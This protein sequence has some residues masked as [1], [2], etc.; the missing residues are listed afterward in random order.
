MRI[1]VK[2]GCSIMLGVWL[3]LDGV[4]IGAVQA[5]SE[6]WREF[7]ALDNG[8]GRG[9][10]APSQQAATLRKL[11]YDGISYNYTTPADLDVWLKEVQ[12]HGL[13]LHGLYFPVRIDEPEPYPAG[14][15]EAVAKLKGRETVLWM[16]LPMPPGQGNHETKAI[17]RVQDLADLAKTAGLRVSIYPHK[18][19][20]VATAEEALRIVRQTERENVGLTINLC[21]ELASGN[22]PRLK[23]IVRLAAPHLTMVTING[24]TD[25]PGQGWNNYIQTLDRGDYDV[26]GVLEVLQEVNY[27][28]PIGLQCYNI[29]GDPKEN[30]KRSME[31][32][33][34]YT[35]RF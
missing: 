13:K 28:G 22:G 15:Q 1:R 29:K 23:G 35:I 26:A 16:T 4:G 19:F 14:L 25:Q 18:G 33:R 8:V 27:R 24:A 11:G 34:N 17:K 5:A 3:V 30:L 9:A 6:K 21:H 10:W 12:L 2:T 32:W 20:Y 7:F 31:A